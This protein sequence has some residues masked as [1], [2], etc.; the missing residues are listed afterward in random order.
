[1]KNNIYAPAAFRKNYVSRIQVYTTVLA[2]FL[3]AGFLSAQPQVDNRFRNARLDR[4]GEQMQ[5]KF[6]LPVHGKSVGKMES[7]FLIP[8]LQN[9]DSILSLPYVRLNGKSRCKALCRNEATQRV[10]VAGTQDI[11]TEEEI[12]STRYQQLIPYQTEV[13][14]APWMTSARLVIREEIYGCAGAKKIQLSTLI[15]S[16]VEETPVSAPRYTTKQILDGIRPQVSYITPQIENKQRSETGSAYLDFPQGQSVILPDYRRNR[17]ELNKIRETL[18]K[19]R[20]DT[21]VEIQEI[22][23]TGFASP[24]GSYAANER[25]S[26]D[27][28]HAVKNY[29]QR[30]SNISS[31]YFEVQPGGEDWETL[32]ELVEDSHLP[33][34]RQILAIIDSP[35]DYDRKEVRLRNMGMTYDMLLSDIY[36][37]LRRVDYRI[38]YW[39]KDF[40]VQESRDM[41]IRNP[42]HLSTYE[43]YRVAGNYTK[44]SDKWNEIIELTVRLHPE[45]DVVNINAA[46]VLL[47]R[48][49]L[50]AAKICL[51][52]VAD[53]PAAW[54]NMGVYY[55]YQGD[56]L[57]ATE[58]FTKALVMGVDETTYNLDIRRQMELYKEE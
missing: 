20:K 39:V 22:V 1:M 15:H 17:T 57:K 55:L 35:E 11:Y 51:D 54:N 9:G 49:D 30:V 14:F 42:G 13:A 53:L 29:L 50:V 52:K 6:D 28:A 45:D 10:G 58:Y 34:S 8:Q 48:G 16:P 21:N 18:E 26:W 44:E 32:R 46:G 41:L 24:E 4:N 12:I 47:N 27:R 2:V 19:T 36:P 37:A 38:E 56:L 31:R 43:L 5:V 33:D 40:T 25:L 23:I 3:F 7:V